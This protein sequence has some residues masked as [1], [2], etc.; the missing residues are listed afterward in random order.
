MGGGKGSNTTTSSF[1]LP[2]EFIKA[3]NESLGLARQAI[4]QPYTPYTGQLVAGLTPGQQQGISNIQASQG[5][6]LPGIQQ[7]MAYT[8]EAARGITPELYE[9]FYSPYVRDV[10]NATQANLLESAAQQRTGLKGE[11]IQAGAFGGDRGGIAQ[12]EM[13]RQQQLAHSQAMANIHNQGYT[14][15][16]NLAGNQVTNLGAMGQQMAN[17]GTAAQTSALTGAQAQLAAGAQEQITAQAQLQAAYD[18]FLQQQSYPFQ[19]SQYFANIAQG[20]GST[21]GGTSTTTAPPPSAASQIMG[22]IGA[23]GSIAS[24]LPPSDKRMKEN[25]EAVGTLNDGQT[26][27]RYNFKGDPQTQIGLLAQEVEERKPGSVVEVGGI[28]R[29]D[30]KGATDDAAS[31]MGGVVSPG[32]DRQGFMNGGTPY[33]GLG[34]VPN[35]PMM[36]GASNKIPGAAA[37]TPD[38]GFAGAG[39]SDPF[40]DQQKEGFGKIA[41][42]FQKPSIY[43][44]GGVVGRNTYAEGGVPFMPY[45]GSRG[46]VPEGKIGGGGSA[47]PS[48][49]DAYVDKGLAEGWKDI[50]PF[51]DDQKEGLSLLPG[52]IRAMF[53]EPD[54]AAAGFTGLP[55]LY[56]TGNPQLDKTP[57]PTDFNYRFARGG[58]AGRNGYQFGGE[59]TM[60]EAMAEAEAMREPQG[61]AGGDYSRLL[62][63]ESGNNFAARNK[64]GYVGR[65]QFGDARLE[66]AR[67]AGVMPEGLT[68]K[69]FRLSPNTQKAVEDWHFSDINQF[70]DQRGLGSFEGKSIAGVPVTRDG[71]VNVAHLGGKGGLEKFIT[72]GGQY[73]PADANGTR[74]SDYLAM[75]SSSG[76][77]GAAPAPSGYSDTQIMPVS[78][79]VAPDGV[80]AAEKDRTPFSL[81]KLFASEENPSII[82]SIMGRRMSPE[83]RN[84]VLNASFA[85]MAGKSPFFMTNLG[86]AGRVGTQTYYNALQQKRETEKQRADIAR[87]AYEAE[88]GRMSAQTQLATLEQQKLATLYPLLRGYVQTNQPI[89]PSLLNLI[90]GMYPKGTP[91]R[92][93]LETDLGGPIVS[94]AEAPVPGV[95]A[96]GEAAAA[97][98]SAPGT[99]ATPAVTEPGEEAGPVDELRSIYEQLPNE[100]NPYWLEEQARIADQ[101]AQSA[102]AVVDFERENQQ[103]ELAR[104]YRE[105]AKKILEQD[106]KR[107]YILVPGEGRVPFPGALEQELETAG[108]L[109]RQKLSI[110]AVDDFEDSIESLTDGFSQKG[111]T[112]NGLA[113]ALAKGETGALAEMKAYVTNVLNSLDLAGA[114]EVEQATNIQDVVRFLGEGLANNPDA[115]QNFGPQISN[116]DIKIMMGVQGSVSD[117]P[118]ANRR[119]VGAALGKLAWD[120]AKVAVWQEFSEEMDAKGKELT[121]RDIT[122]FKSDFSSGKYTDG[123]TAQDY[124]DEAIANTPVMG[125]VNWTNV[126]KDQLKKG[127]KYIIPKGSYPIGTFETNTVVVWDGKKL[128]EVE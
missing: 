122:K 75:G 43:N 90:E 19:I 117:L 11:A 127:Y 25:I 86:E 109:E 82:E 56:E 20:L 102:R 114:D 9:Q 42:L 107:K 87:Q 81:K 26:V 23:L 16:M 88:T 34:F 4:Q 1:E 62:Q 74:L 91:E 54:M 14:Q 40:T 24:A 50:K 12:A 123:K 104:K 84:A 118:G 77:V 48:E 116:A 53:G 97:S 59:P 37:P 125:D 92:R 79:E 100:R 61:V 64:Q 95:A 58:V 106:E 72:S 108:K 47:I 101:N 65:A 93:Q 110:E 57:M 80:A 55:S 71:L 69:G 63:K 52:K 126:K 17:L 35:S 76:G 28:K 31:S 46:W 3:Y 67:R 22:G 41:G 2:P 66:D 32:D 33:G 121:R 36:T 96:A 5:M 89:P 45:S 30:Y 27:Y 44:A 111:L 105:D 39:M 49:P 13:A 112:L 124:V 113:N 85:L 103:K 73:N 6:A 120:R 68:K 15:A 7:G 21:A 78:A 18:Q 38:A 60:E 115:K 8:T 94:A 29:V 119:V 70:I 51:T 10:A 98:P 83:A 128:K 99:P